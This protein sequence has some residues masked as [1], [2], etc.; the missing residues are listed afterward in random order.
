VGQWVTGTSWPMIHPDLLTHYPWSTGPLSVRERVSLKYC[1]G[2]WVYSCCDLVSGEHCPDCATSLGPATLV[3]IHSFLLRRLSRV[4]SDASII[5]P[6]TRQCSRTTGVTS[7]AI[8]CLN[9]RRRHTYD[10]YHYE[11]A[12]TGK[13]HQVIAVKVCLFVFFRMFEEITK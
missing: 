10:V 6:D 12:T 13:K 7:R 2:L 9:S 5:F 1:R 3:D 4:I 11:S 8:R